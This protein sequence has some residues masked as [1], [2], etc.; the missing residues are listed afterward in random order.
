M[1][2][3]KLLNIPYFITA[4]AKGGISEQVNNKYGGIYG[5]RA[6]TD[7]VRLEVENADLALIIGYYPV[8]L[9]HP[10]DN[11]PPC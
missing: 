2:L 11:M 7:N 5:G 6:S 3:I 8:R 4:M 9:T 10:Q 1:A